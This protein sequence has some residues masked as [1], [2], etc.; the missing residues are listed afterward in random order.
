MIRRGLARTAL[1]VA[2]GLAGAAASAQAPA[3]AAPPVRPPS[4]PAL[5]DLETAAK[6]LAG[7]QAKAAALNAHIAVCVMDARGDMVAFARM[8][9]ADIGPSTTAIGKAHTVL[10]FGLPTGQITDAMSA[11]KTVPAMVKAPIPGQ[12]NLT[13]FRGGLPIVKG[14]KVIGSI[15]VGGAKT[16]LDDEAIAQAGIDA[17]MP[18]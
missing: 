10:V 2:L 5:M 13:F 16:E 4:P 12:D 11:G 9:G 8:N 15:G 1:V 7:A 6:A 17:A 14:G 3:Q 18:K